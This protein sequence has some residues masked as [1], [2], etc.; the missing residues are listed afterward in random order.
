MI[1]MSMNHKL[2]LP[3]LKDFDFLL[4]NYSG[5]V[6]REIQGMRDGMWLLLSQ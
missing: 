3:H 6:R 5:V 4:F 1:I 2:W